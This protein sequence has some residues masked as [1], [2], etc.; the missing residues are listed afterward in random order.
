MKKLMI[1]CLMVSSSVLGMGGMGSMGG[2]FGLIKAYLSELAHKPCRPL[3]SQVKQVRRDPHF[4]DWHA[5]EGA[6]S[7]KHKKHKKLRKNSSMQ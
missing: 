2:E 1:L 5:Q 6:S 3:P 4:A 7:K